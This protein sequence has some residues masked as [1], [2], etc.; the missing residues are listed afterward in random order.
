M[1]EPKVDVTA[2]VGGAPELPSL[3]PITTVQPV[4]LVRA[5]GGVPL[6]GAAARR[7][8][9]GVMGILSI[10]WLV[11]IVALAVLAPILPIEDPN[12]IIASIARQPPGTDGHI[13]GGDV[14]GRDMLSRLIWG[15]RASLLI[16]TLSVLLGLVLGGGRGVGGHWFCAPFRRRG[17][18]LLLV[19]CC[20]PRRR[21]E[22][23]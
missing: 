9:L 12:K 10:S 11:L 2:D 7:G 15:A 21:V 5:D 16:G 1:P 20:W 8:R 4:D 23:A 6:T 19:R 22:F 17:V 3:T 18:V 13:L 14:L